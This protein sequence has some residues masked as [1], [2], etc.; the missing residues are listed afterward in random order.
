MK[1]R[2]G[3]VGGGQLARMLTFEAK[4]MGFFVTVLDPT[5][6]AP[7]GQ[8]A[9]RHIIADLND[10]IAMMQ[11]ASHADFLT[12]DWELANPDI[13][14]KIEKKGI[15][16]NPSPKTLRI[17]KDKYQQ[18][19]FLQKHKIPVAPFIEIKTE[20]DIQKAIQKFGYPFL[21]KAKLGA[22]DGKGNYLIKNKHDIVKAFEKLGKENLYVEQFIPF[23]KELA[24]MVSQSITGEIKTFPLVET[25]HKNNILHMTIAP[26]PVTKAIA[27]KAE[28]LAEKVM[29]HLKGAGVFGLE[30]FLTKNGEVL[31]NEIAPRVHNSGHY[32]S[33]A[34]MTSQFAQHIRSITAMPLGKTDMVT[35][36]AV[37]V[38]ILG[39]RNGAATLQGLEKVL[40]LPATTVHIYG[41]A[42]TKK[43][44]KMGHITVIGKTVKHCI[45]QAKKARRYIQI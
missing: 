6:H 34:C 22:Y 25:I 26:A 38:N 29:H 4:K 24:I 42:E 32:T 3:I 36:A 20:K 33:E 43:E 7:G 37:M 28:T 31:I 13:L 1:N 44:R 27:K 35:P 8:V 39:E 17:I 15:P 19:V 16:V 11:L 40:S 2:I 9:D 30:M 18:K 14:E 21:L 45:A 5:P 10:E 12:L 23:E 41:K